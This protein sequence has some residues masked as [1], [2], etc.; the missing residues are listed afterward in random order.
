MIDFIEKHRSEYGVEP[1]CAVLPIA[2]A[3]YY[4]HLAQRRDPEVACA[5]CKA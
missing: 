4:E 1:I 2:Q 5:A 3:T